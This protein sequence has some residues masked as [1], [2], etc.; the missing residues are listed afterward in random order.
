MGF[1]R[2]CVTSAAKSV[3]KRPPPS[4]APSGGV[5][6]SAALTGEYDTYNNSN[7]SQGPYW[8]EQG[9]WN[10]FTPSFF[11]NTTAAGRARAIVKPSNS[12]TNSSEGSVRTR[13][14]GNS[15]KRSGMA[16]TRQV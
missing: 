7:G 1:S 5:T 10:D 15:A 2:S 12:Y 13:S 16:D 3:C 11:G 6:I 8:I 9:I 14:G 4:P